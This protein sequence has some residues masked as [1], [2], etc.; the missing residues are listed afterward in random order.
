[1]K[2]R[3]AVMACDGAAH[4]MAVAMT[5]VEPRVSTMYI[6]SA[7]GVVGRRRSPP[8]AYRGRRHA[9]CRCLP[10]DTCTIGPRRVRSS[11]AAR[12]P[13][14]PAVRGKGRP[15]RIRRDRSWTAWPA[16][17]HA[18]MPAH[19]RTRRHGQQVE[20]AGDE[21][22]PDQHRRQRPPDPVRRHIGLHQHSLRLSPL[23]VSSICH[24]FCGGA[25]PTS[26]GTAA[27]RIG[28]PP[29]AGRFAL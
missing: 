10:R 13:L 2:F 15:P 1:M 12:A 8:T 19:R 18:A 20:R 23:P 24:F 26:A 7:R 5:S 4:G 21:L 14:A 3:V 11:G 25:A 9:P 28:H 27:R 16:P 17:S 29:R 22:G 6:V